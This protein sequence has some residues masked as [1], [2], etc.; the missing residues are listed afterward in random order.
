VVAGARG[1]PPE[2]LA[3][4]QHALLAD[5]VRAHVVGGVPGDVGG[6]GAHPAGADGGDRGA[7][8]REVAE[9]ERRVA[10][11]PD[12]PRLDLRHGLGQAQG[13]APAG[14]GREG[15]LVGLAGRRD[16]GGEGQ[17]RV[18][19]RPAG[20]ALDLDP[21]LHAARQVVQA[22]RPPLDGGELGAGAGAAGPLGPPAGARRLRGRAGRVGDREVAA[23]RD[24]GVGRIALAAGRRLD[25][26]VADGGRRRP[27]RAGEEGAERERAHEGAAL[28]RARPHE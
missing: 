11:D 20:A 24:L 9:R 25:V 5:A 17:V 19:H 4:H 1:A 15:H 6:V 21:Q 23:G 28:R 10:D 26:D 3:G 7:G 2:R 8:R 18:A 27:G 12:P 16:V 14:A 22:Q 13:H